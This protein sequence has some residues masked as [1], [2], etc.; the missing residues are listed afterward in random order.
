[1]RWT[2]YITR[3]GK[4]RTAYKIWSENLKGIHHSEDLDV[5]GMIILERILG[6]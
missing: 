5:N 4:I 2:G 6:T 1:M 3:V